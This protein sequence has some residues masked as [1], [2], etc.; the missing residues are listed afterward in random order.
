MI[1]GILWEKI[2]IECDETKIIE[3]FP[4]NREC[5]GGRG[6]SCK[7]CCNIKRKVYHAK[8]RADPVRNELFREKFRKYIRQY[9]AENPEKRGSKEYR[10]E[11]NKANRDKKLAYHHTRKA[12]RFGGGGRHSSEAWSQ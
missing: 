7:A 1:Q 11:Y 3:D 9:L 5:K 4:K 2:C 10:Q 6:R 8:I 12:R